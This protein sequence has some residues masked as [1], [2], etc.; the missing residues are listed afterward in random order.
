MG[1]GLTLFSIVLA[2]ASAILIARETNRQ[3]GRDP[4]E[5]LVVAQ[6]VV[7][8]DFNIDDGHASLKVASAQAHRVF[9][10]VRA[11]VSGGLGIGVRGHP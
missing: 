1:I 11:E 7:D 2:A 8:G 6:R 4:G 9:K 10:P 3:L 5:L